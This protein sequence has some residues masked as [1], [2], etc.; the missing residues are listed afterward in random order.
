[1]RRRPSL[2][3][4]Q[5][6]SLDP[7]GP[8]PLH[9]QLYEEVRTAIL[10]AR[11]APGTRMPASRDLA[12]GARISRNTVLAAFQQLLAEGYLTSRAGSGT[13]VADSI[14]DLLAPVRA[15]AHAGR[16][17]PDG[18]RELSSLGRSLLDGL[19]LAH[20]YP[21]LSDTF[22]SG[23]PA[24]DEF[25]YAIWRR[26]FDRR[27]Q[28]SS[29]K[30]LAYG[31]PQGY[32]PLR[33]A[34][35]QHL[36]AARGARCTPE[37]IVV[38]S[39]SQQAIDLVTRVLMEPGQAAW[40]EDPGYYIALA[41]MRCAGARVVPVPVDHEGLVVEEGVRQAPDARLAYVTPSHQHPLGTVMS[42]PRRL[43]LLQW[44]ERAGAWILEDDYASEYRYTG[45]P[46]A[47]LQGLDE[48]RRVLYVGTFSK[49][50]FASLRLG[51]VVAPLDLVPALVRAREVSDRQS[52]TLLQAV[53]ADFMHEGHF[54]RHLR[55]MRTL[56]AHRQKV[57]VTA[58]ERHLAGLLEI[59]PSEAGMNLIGW[60]PPG[61]D[62]REA[63]RAAEHA[64]LFAPPL[65]RFA[66]RP[67]P[68]GGLVLGY[69]GLHDDQIEAGAKR[70]A[71]AL[72]PVV[73]AASSRR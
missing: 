54:S 73:A 8:V 50:L 67:Q 56:Y 15:T 17:E 57:L 19:G 29:S 63:A 51:Y 33:E 64:Q 70:L 39:G 47:A 41:A 10:E 12:R 6:V 40:F 25:P 5:P 69:T 43:A 2:V 68:R 11:L 34:I 16:P 14:P 37:Q 32:R 53:T 30:L 44:A 61:V 72:R 24:L 9:R 23:L 62:D 31:D 3:S 7:A 46:L 35:A 36:A 42:L 22:R 4:F 60:L 59:S 48:R 20:E 45:R 55:R 18:P 13:Y 21:V 66:I 27:L 52:P 26:L 28:T 49:V 38:L 58:A 1:M 65:S 71:D